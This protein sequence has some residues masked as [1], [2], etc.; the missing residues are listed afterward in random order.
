MVETPMVT[1]WSMNYCRNIAGKL[2]ESMDTLKEVNCCCR[3]K[4]TAKKL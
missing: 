4:E 2:R 1:F 3:L